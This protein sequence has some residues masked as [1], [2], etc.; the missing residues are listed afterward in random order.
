MHDDS[1]IG[2]FR[3]QLRSQVSQVF[4]VTSHIVG[5]FALHFVSP[6]TGAPKTFFNFGVLAGVKKKT[7]NDKR[8]NNHRWGED[9]IK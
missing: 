2:D 8:Q 4:Q 1:C 5:I 6:Q 9:Q 3:S 7:N